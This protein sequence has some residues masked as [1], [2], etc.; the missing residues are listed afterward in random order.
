MKRKNL[1]SLSLK[2]SVISSIGKKRIV[3]GGIP[4]DDKKFTKECP[5][6][7]TDCATCFQSC[8]ATC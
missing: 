5:T 8:G 6:N 7:P 2:K 3:G 1:K 4:W